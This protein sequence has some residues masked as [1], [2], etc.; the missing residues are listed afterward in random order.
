MYERSNGTADLVVVELETV[1]G[2]RPDDLND[3]AVVVLVLQGEETG[4]GVHTH[5]LVDQLA[6]LNQR[7]Q[8]I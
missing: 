6:L 3:G 2:Q 5:E 8:N 4:G 1:G 7:K